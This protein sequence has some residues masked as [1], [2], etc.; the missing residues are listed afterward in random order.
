MVRQVKIKIHQFHS[1]SSVVDAVTNCMFFGQSMLQS[2]GFESDIFVEHV[3]PALSGRIRRLERHDA[4]D[5][6][7]D[8]RCR[9]FFV[10][11]NITPPRF[12]DESDPTH[13]YVLKGCFQ[14]SQFRDIVESA[15][16][17][18]SFNGQQLRQRGFD[19]VTVVPLLKDFTA[20]RYAQHSRTP[21]HDKVRSAP[22]SV[23]RKAHA[24]QM[25]TPAVDGVTQ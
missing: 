3:D 15:I 18:S 10:Y 20:I 21:F 13:S 4:F 22:A 8:L 2:F 6:L 17:V 7:A 11:H 1:G 23:C 14:L 24:A 25:P 5:W 16:A 12:F 19:D 9:R